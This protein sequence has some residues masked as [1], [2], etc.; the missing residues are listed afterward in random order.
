MIEIFQAPTGHSSEARDIHDVLDIGQWEPVKWLG[1]VPQLFWISLVVGPRW[2]WLTRRKSEKKM[3]SES[4][5]GEC[6]ATIEDWGHPMSP[7]IVKSTVD[8]CGSGKG[9]RK[10][11]LLI[12]TE[13]SSLRTE[14]QGIEFIQG[15]NWL[16]EYVDTC[17]WHLQVLCN[18]IR[19]YC[20]GAWFWPH[21]RL[22]GNKAGTQT[23]YIAIPPPDFSAA[24]KSPNSGAFALWWCIIIMITLAPS[25]LWLILS[26]HVSPPILVIKNRLNNL[27]ILND[28]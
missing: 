14:L 11:T 10:P 6:K 16:P 20:F 27:M 17:C 24:N 28:T 18:I 9:F 22:L 26:L 3:N 15:K 13:S 19:N 12:T 8:H 25:V 2:P 5:Y 7:L 4:I 21:D 1:T 23:M